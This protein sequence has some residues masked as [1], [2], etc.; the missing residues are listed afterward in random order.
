MRIDLQLL[1]PRAR[2]FD[3][4][5]NY[6]VATNQ[7]IIDGHVVSCVSTGTFVA[8]PDHNDIE[9]R[10]RMLE[11]IVAGFKVHTARV[12]SGCLLIQIF[13]ISHCIIKGFLFNQ[14]NLTG[15]L[16]FSIALLNFECLTFI[17]C[18]CNSY[19]AGLLHF[20][21]STRP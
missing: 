8:W 9:G 1:V 20:G 6:M 4:N 12:K 15:S 14:A 11:I 17:R 13:S 10:H 5:E 7:F 21:L 16:Y 2:C 18:I 19:R 3:N